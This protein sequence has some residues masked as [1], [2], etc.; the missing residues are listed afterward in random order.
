[1][2]SSQHTSRPTS[3]PRSRHRK[4]KSRHLPIYL[5]PAL[6]TLFLFLLVGFA[7]AGSSDRIAPGVKIAGVDVGGLS[8]A[9]ARQKLEKASAKLTWVPV[10]LVARD[11]HYEVAPAQL[12]II[13]NWDAAIERRAA[14]ATESRRC[15]DTSD[16]R[17]GCSAGG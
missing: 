1:M 13:V 9:Q 17:C 5:A 2:S 12:G 15:V 14:T 10:E 4:R 7:F 8:A 3:H 16:W 11:S 6:V